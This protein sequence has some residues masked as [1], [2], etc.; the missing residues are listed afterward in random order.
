[1]TIRSL[2]LRTAYLE[3]KPEIDVAV[4]NGFA[5]HLATRTRRCI[6]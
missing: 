5:L 1:M 4:A 6:N 2:D 3:L